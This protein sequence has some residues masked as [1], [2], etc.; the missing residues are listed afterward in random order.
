MF[1][2]ALNLSESP[3]RLDDEMEQNGQ[4][5]ELEGSGMNTN[6]SSYFHPLL[7]KTFTLASIPSIVNHQQWTHSK[8]SNSILFYFEDQNQIFRNRFCDFIA[9]IVRGTRQEQSK[10]WLQLVEVRDF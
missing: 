10:G 6:A 4:N 1:F 9:I 5:Q 7:L 3:F 2:F 8:Q